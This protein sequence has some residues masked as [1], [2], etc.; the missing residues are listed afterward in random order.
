MEFVATL[1]KILS[2]TRGNW[3]LPEKQPI[4]RLSF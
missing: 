4:K 1:E 3:G 2:I